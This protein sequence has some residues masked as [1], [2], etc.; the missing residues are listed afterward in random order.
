MN[1]VKQ[2][3]ILF[4]ALSQKIFGIHLQ[5][6]DDLFICRLGQYTKSRLRISSSAYGILAL[7]LQVVLSTI[8]TYLY[9]VSI[10]DKEYGNPSQTPREMNMPLRTLVTIFS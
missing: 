6:I 4:G 9:N 7:L 1:D 8:G 5:L 10:H 2:L 3:T